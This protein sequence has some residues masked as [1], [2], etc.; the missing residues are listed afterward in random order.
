[1]IGPEVVGMLPIN[2]LHMVQGVQFMQRR[3]VCRHDAGSVAVGALQQ[4]P[5]PS[6]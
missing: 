1:M 3:L 5:A 4:D 2:R 6:A